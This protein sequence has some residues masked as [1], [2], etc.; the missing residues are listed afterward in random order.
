MSKTN[1]SE[2]DFE[3]RQLQKRIAELEQQLKDAEMK[4]IAFSTMVDIAGYSAQMT[5]LKVAV[6]V[7]GYDKQKVQWVTCLSS[8][9]ACSAGRPNF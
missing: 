5:V 4:A 3:K 9:M 2:Q 6:Y 1:P 8:R 7:C